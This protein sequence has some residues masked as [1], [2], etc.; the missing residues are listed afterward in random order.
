MDKK[1]KTIPLNRPNKKTPPTDD[2]RDYCI[3]CYRLFRGD[4]QY[5]SCL[6]VTAD[7]LLHGDSGAKDYKKT[8]TE[9]E[10]WSAFA[11]IGLDC[12]RKIGYIK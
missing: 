4:A 9:D 10:Y 6:L 11:N 2:N 8:V 1:L 5:L 7:S 12:A 3:R